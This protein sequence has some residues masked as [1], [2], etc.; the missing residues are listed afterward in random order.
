MAL[1][2]THAYQSQGMTQEPWLGPDL[3]TVLDRAKTDGFRQVL[4]VPVGFLTDHVETLYDLDIEAKQEAQ[5]RGLRLLRCPC[6]NLHEKL[7]RAV[8]DVASPLLAQH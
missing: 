3:M 2:H 7:I 6:P 4:L 8:V 1:R 5:A